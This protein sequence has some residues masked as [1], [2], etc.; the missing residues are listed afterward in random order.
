MLT[1]IIQA[2]PA[3]AEQVSDEECP[4]FKFIT[5]RSTPAS[6]FIASLSLL[7][8]AAPAMA[9]DAKNEDQMLMKVEKRRGMTVYCYDQALTGSRIPAHS[10]YTKSEWEH[11]GAYVHD[12][13]RHQDSKQ[14]SAA[15]EKTSDGES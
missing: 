8:L 11:R 12:D 15:A 10:C 4:M 2:Q 9:A 3:E 5:S 6:L 1:A 13:E 7:S 14:R